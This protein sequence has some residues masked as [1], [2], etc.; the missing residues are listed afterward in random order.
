MSKSD[1]SPGITYSIDN[2]STATE[3][4]NTD[5]ENVTSHLL[6]MQAREFEIAQ[7]QQE[8]LSVE[9]IKDRIKLLDHQMQAAHRAL[10][11]MSGGALFADEV[12][13]GKTIEVGMVLK[14]MDFRD[15]RDTF[16][17]LTP[18]QLAPQWQKELQEKFGLDFVCNYDDDFRGFD[19]HDKIIASVDTAKSKTN[20]EDVLARRW[21]V[22]VLGRSPLRSK[23]RHDAV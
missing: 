12:G 20:R 6:N 7:G 5:A 13:L 2:F 1:L 17:I 22:A 16:L 18:A 9:E 10:F 3:A 15:T 8:L 11:K 4:L 14:E 21:D 23:C 19:A